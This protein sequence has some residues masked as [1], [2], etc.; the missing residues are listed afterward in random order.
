VTTE[1]VTTETA[2]AG[3]VTT[4]IVMTGTV[5]TG[6][7]RKGCETARGRP[8]Q[9]DGAAIR[10]RLSRRAIQMVVATGPGARRIT[11][12]LSVY[13]PRRPVP[14]KQG[15]QESQGSQEKRRKTTLHPNAESSGTR[16]AAGRRVMTGPG[17]TKSDPMTARDVTTRRIAQ[18]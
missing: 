17:A 5:M 10:T 15:N 13:P 1:T 9:A 11:N 6:T 18:T 16:I 2:K 12:R 7:V 3:T 4:G 8:G 14:G